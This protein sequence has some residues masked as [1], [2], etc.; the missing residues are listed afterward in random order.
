MIDDGCVHCGNP[1]APESLEY[2]IGLIGQDED[3]HLEFHFCDVC[4]R[5]FT[6]DVATFN[7]YNNEAVTPDAVFSTLNSLIEQAIE[8]A[9]DGE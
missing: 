5:T 7:D 6:L 2:P 3:I 9:T 4:H 8:E 1:D